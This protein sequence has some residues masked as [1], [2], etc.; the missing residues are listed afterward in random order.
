[1]STRINKRQRADMTAEQFEAFRKEMK[2][3]R[4]ESKLTQT[5]MSELLECS[6]T[7]VNNI[8]KGVRFPSDELMKDI[9]DIFGLTVDAMLKDHTERRFDMFAEVGKTFRDKRVARGFSRC[10][11][12]GFLGIPKEVYADFED[13]KCSIGESRMEALDRL[14]KVEKEVETVEV[15]KEVPTPS[16]IS[17]WEIDKVLAHITDIDLDVVEQKALFKKFSDVRTKLLEAE[18]FG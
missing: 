3:L 18:L 2:R 13:G 9:A 6:A 4:E 10:E 7:H 11:V 15:V 8:E 12:A 5:A 1:M 14:F 17:I 16:P